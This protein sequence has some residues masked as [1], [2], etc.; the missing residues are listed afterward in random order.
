MKPNQ[1]I[2][3]PIYDYI[4]SPFDCCDPTTTAKRVLDH[5]IAST[6]SVLIHTGCQRLSNQIVG[7]SIVMKVIN[8]VHGR[9]FHWTEEIPSF[10]GFDTTFQL[11]MFRQIGGSNL[12]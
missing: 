5:C 7:F 3:D 6:S 11:R 9:V 1:Q 2:Q 4:D 12:G 8:L 10:R